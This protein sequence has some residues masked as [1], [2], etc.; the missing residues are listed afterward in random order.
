MRRRSSNSRKGESG[1]GEACG[2]RKGR[3]REIQISN[4]E[5][6]APS[7]DELQSERWWCSEVGWESERKPRKS[8]IDRE[9]IGEGSR[10]NKTGSTQ[11]MKEARRSGLDVKS[12]ATLQSF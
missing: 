4:F 10:E 9:G 3:R 6:V 7:F 8:G 1:G 12:I 5:I 2:W 11:V